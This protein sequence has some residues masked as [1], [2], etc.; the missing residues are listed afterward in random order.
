MAGYYEHQLQMKQENYHQIILN[1]DQL[2]EQI[3]NK[4]LSLL[5]KIDQENKQLLKRNY[6]IEQQLLFRNNEFQQHK[7]QIEQQ[8]AEIQLLQRRIG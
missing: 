8:A 4:Y 5:D 2:I 1:K 7:D 6:E 3:S